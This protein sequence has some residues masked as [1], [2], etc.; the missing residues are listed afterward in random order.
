MMETKTTSKVKVF[1]VK[2][3]E[4]KSEPKNSSSKTLTSKSLLEKKLAR[5]DRE[6]QALVNQ[7]L[8]ML[9]DG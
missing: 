1:L 5:L 9:E 7:L 2:S 8:D 3:Q 6:A 4:P